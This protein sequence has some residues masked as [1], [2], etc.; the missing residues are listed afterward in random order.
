MGLALAAILF[1]LANA[2]Y[3]FLQSPKEPAPAQKAPAKEIR[4]DDLKQWLIEQE[5]RANEAPKPQQ[6][7]GQPRAVEYL[8]EATALYRCSESFGKE[9]GAEIAAASDFEVTQ[10]V[11]ELRY[12]IEQ[13]A[14]AQD[15]RGANWVKAAVNFTCAALKDPS[16]IAL[17]KDG[18]VTKVFMPV[19]K[20][21]LTAWDKIE[22]EKRNFEQAESNRVASE[23]AAETMRV[24]LAKAAALSYLVAAGIAFGVFMALALYLVFAKIETNLREINQSI[25][26]TEEA[27]N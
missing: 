18:K 10:R 17:K 1:L 16:I 13:A 27:R 11:S 5:K 21:H 7:P 22:T 19:L 24:S 2:A 15:W 4:L 6:A 23:R 12:Q 25:L 8:E 3:Q 20:F 14:N 26:G 9:V